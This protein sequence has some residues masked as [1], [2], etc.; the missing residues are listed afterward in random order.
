MR[1]F[2][3]ETFEHVGVAARKVPNIARIK[4]IR[5]GLSRR[6]NY[7]R[8]RTPC[9][10]KGPLRRGRMPMKFAHY[11]RLQLPRHARDSLRDR[12]LLG[13]NFLPETV[14]QNF[15]LRFLQFELKRG[16]F[17]SGQQRIGNIVLETDVTH[18][19]SFLAR[20][21]RANQDNHGSPDVFRTVIGNLSVSVR[22]QEWQSAASLQNA[23][24]WRILN[25]ST[26]RKASSRI[27]PGRSSCA[28]DS[29]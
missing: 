28:A 26:F 18:N 9:D 22:N 7:C 17:F 10:D 13:C 8:T 14:P 19:G 15:A 20:Y 23:S 25:H 1:G 29:I 12:Q 27:H 21:I 4:I 11:S 24:A 3:A 5:F 6:V 16:Q 2:I